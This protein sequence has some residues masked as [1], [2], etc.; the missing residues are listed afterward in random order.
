V[1]VVVRL[2]S[3]FAVQVDDRVVGADAFARRDA[4]RL[5]QLLALAPGSRLHREQ[6]LDALWSDV[7]PDIAPNRLHKAAYYARQATRMSDAVTL[8]NDVVALFPDR[9]VIVD[10][11]TFDAAARAALADGDPMAVESALAM[12][13][14]ELLPD[15]PYAA[16]AFQPRQRVE[17]LRRELLRACH[18]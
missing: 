13:D 4:A 2:L 15:E 7:E 10:V 6:V 16:W 18:R 3:G 12:Y 5:V 17:M 8:R 1:S 11:P 14:G 9:D